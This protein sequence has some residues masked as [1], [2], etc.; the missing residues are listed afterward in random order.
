MINEK[1]IKSREELELE[2]ACKLY[3]MLAVSNMTDRVDITPQGDMRRMV[4]IVFSI[5][6]FTYENGDY[7][8]FG[9]TAPEPAT[10]GMALYKHLPEV[11]MTLEYN[12]SSSEFM[13]LDLRCDPKIT[14]VDIL[15]ALD[16]AIIDVNTASGNPQRVYLSNKSKEVEDWLRRR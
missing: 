5:A 10:L 7:I 16:D 9:D 15:G 1:S 4:R 12:S 6:T 13:I 14:R 8:P 11:P 2:K 3:G